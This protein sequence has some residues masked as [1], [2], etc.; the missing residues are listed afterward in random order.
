MSIH[1]SIGQEYWLPLL[2]F[3]RSE[4]DRFFSSHRS[5]SLYLA[6]SEDINSYL[7]ELY[8]LKVESQKG[9]VAVCILSH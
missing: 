4:K 3:F 2:R 8:G 5:H 7:S 6:L 9:R 1:L